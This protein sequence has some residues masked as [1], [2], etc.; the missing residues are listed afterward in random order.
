ML[1]SASALSNAFEAFA[2][3]V[4]AAMIAVALAFFSRS[5]FWQTELAQAENLYHTIGAKIFGAEPP[6]R[7]PLPKFAVH[8]THPLAI[9]FAVGSMM[10][11]GSWST[12]LA[13]PPAPVRA[14]AHP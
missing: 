10:A 9:V 2:A 11:F 4:V 8:A 6:P 5:L 12:L 3:G 1:Q 7:V 13:L 14:T